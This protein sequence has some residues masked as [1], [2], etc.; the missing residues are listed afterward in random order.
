MLA[1]QYNIR[2]VDLNQDNIGSDVFGVVIESPE[3]TP[4]AINW[5]NLMIFE[6]HVLWEWSETIGYAIELAGV[7]E[8]C[9]RSRFFRGSAGFSTGTKNIKLS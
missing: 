9:R 5:Y 8:Y 1:S 2:V 7:M 6:I 4:D 3:M